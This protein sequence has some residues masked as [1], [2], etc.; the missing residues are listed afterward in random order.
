[1][2]VGPY[3]STIVPMAFKY[4]SDVLAM[5]Q[6]SRTIAAVRPYDDDMVAVSGGCTLRYARYILV[7]V[8]T[9]RE[10]GPC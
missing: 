4:L 2:S 6:F 9:S 5:F 8:N 7:S 3:T 1:M 10:D